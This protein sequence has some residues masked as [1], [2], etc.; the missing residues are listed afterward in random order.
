MV[1]V[2][3]G[4][5]LPKAEL[6]PKLW[7][8]HWCRETPWNSTEGLQSPC[9][10]YPSSL[11]EV[12]KALSDGVEAKGPSWHSSTFRSHGLDYR[13]W[14]F[15]GCLVPYTKN[16]SLRL[17]IRGTPLWNERHLLRF[18]VSLKIPGT[19]WG[20][21]VRKYSDDSTRLQVANLIEHLGCNCHETG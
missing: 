7:I 20:N 4:P 21:M 10:S 13:S 2:L 15:G 1:V 18:V 8:S 5:W 6:Q 17:V 3:S 19:S 14:T 16:K 11:V 12:C 9:Q